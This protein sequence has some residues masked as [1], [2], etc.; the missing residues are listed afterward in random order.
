MQAD[1]ASPR[2]ELTLY[3]QPATHHALHQSISDP[4]VLVP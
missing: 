2:D 3:R 4:Y 1:N